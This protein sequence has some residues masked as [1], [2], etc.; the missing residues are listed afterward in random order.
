MVNLK[1]IPEHERT[2]VVVELLEVIDGL[3]ELVRQL[4][5][6][7]SRL[8]GQKPKP[9]IKPSQMEKPSED[10]KRSEKKKGKR[11]GSDK[12][13]KTQELEIHEEK[14]I[15][16]EHLPD[17]SRFKG[18]EEFTVQDIIIMPFNT[19]YL[20]ERWKT[21]DGEYVTAK[22]PDSVIDHFGLNLHG[23][24]LYQYFHCCVTQPLIL[25]MLNEIGIDISAGK[26]NQIIA[27]GME[28]FENEKDEI[29]RVGLEVSS[30]VNVDDTG[31]R[32]QGKN[33]FCTHIGNEFF[34][35]FESAESKSRINFLELLR[36]GAGGYAINED[37]LDYM[38]R[39]KL[40]KGALEKFK[41]QLGLCFENEEAWKDNL[42]SS[43]VQTERHIRIATEGALMGCVIEN[44]FNK[45]TVIISDDAGQFNVF[46]HGLCWIHAERLLAKLVG[47]NENQRKALEKKRGEVWDLY[48]ELKRYK[49]SPSKRKKKKIA[50]LFDKIFTEKTCF[51]TLNLNLKRIHKNKSELLLVF[52]R[53]EIPLHNN[54]SERDIREYVKRRKISGSTRSDQGRESR[55]IMLSLKKTCRK[56]KVSFWEYLTD[57]LSASYLIPPLSDL[58]RLKAL[59]AKL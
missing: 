47:F 26:V 29:L 15:K 5:D 23:F 43:S 38:E 57:R 11:P 21:P 33:G 54:L 4:K 9:D 58:I 51:Q 48:D 7:I 42:K 8:K 50:E 53:P 6:E 55:D 25:E 32:H 36:A 40:P 56:L 37:A 44:G 14:R 31:S 10:E 16:P 34:A 27:E 18:Y 22:L 12:R 46:L 45:N 59:E 24:V 19:C 3:Q 39:Q 28:I 30:Y 52:E 49:Q 1:N 17:G 20:L 2:P 13:R 41:L 35:W